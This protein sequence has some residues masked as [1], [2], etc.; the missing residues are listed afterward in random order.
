MDPVFASKD[1]QPLSYERRVDRCVQMTTGVVFT[2]V[3]KCAFPGRKP[4]G[5]YRL[6][7]TPKGFHGAHGARHLYNTMGGSA[8]EVDYLLPSQLGPEDEEP[9]DSLRLALQS[10]EEGETLVMFV[11][12]GEQYVLAEAMDLAPWS[13]L[14]W[15]IHRGMQDILV[16]FAR[17]RMDRHRAELADLLGN[18][19]HPGWRGKVC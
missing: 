9:P 7:H 18:A 16:G 15:S 13:S 3:F 1:V 12:R 8:Y 4:P 2:P 19:R 5:R 6:K 17:P 10:R 14:P 11:P